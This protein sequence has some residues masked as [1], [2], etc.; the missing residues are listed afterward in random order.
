MNSKRPPGIEK[1]AEQHE[2][3]GRAVT[4]IISDFAASLDSRPVATDALP[5]DLEAIFD[6]KLPENGIGLDEILARF[7]SDIAAHA[8]GVPSPRYYGQFNPTPLPIG[9]WAD[10]LCSALNQNAGA[11]RN[12]PTSAM[13]AELCTGSAIRLAMDRRVLALWRVAALRRIYSVEMRS[14]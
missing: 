10:A 7:T 1:L 13:I 3:I 9:V 12:G 14:R 11:W 8:M 4:R 5:S 2:H 6:E